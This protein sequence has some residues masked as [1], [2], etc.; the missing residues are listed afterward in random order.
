MQKSVGQG[1]GVS[2]MFGRQ[3]L[4]GALQLCQ[5]VQNLHV[6]FRLILLL[7]QRWVKRPKGR[8]KGKVKVQSREG[9][10]G[11]TLGLKR[12]HN[13]RFDGVNR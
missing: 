10:D 3:T 11:V 7:K 9:L 1:K 6:S 4:V 8:D 5:G 13:R 12:A 2:T